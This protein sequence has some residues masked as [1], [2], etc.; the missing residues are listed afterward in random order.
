M[1]HPPH[2]ADTAVLEHGGGRRRAGARKRVGIGLI[3]F[4]WLGQAHSR[5]MLRIPTLFRE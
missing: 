3:G 1:S 4:G 5:S 2:A